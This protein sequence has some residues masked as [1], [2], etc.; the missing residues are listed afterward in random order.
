MNRI[1][2]YVK[3]PGYLDQWVRHHFGTPAVFPRH[4]DQNAVIRTF[5]RRPKPDEVP[6]LDD[7]GLTAIAIPDSIGKP[8]EVWNSISQTGKLA[9]IES[10]QDLFSRA[11]WSDISPLMKNRVKL[12]VMISAWC[13]NNGI[14]EDCSEAVRQRYYRLRKRFAKKGVNI[15]HKKN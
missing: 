15:T 13:E 8:V 10:I 3:L 12:S 6:D 4:S 9:V 11:L 5:L 1:C 14:S 2:I 7:D